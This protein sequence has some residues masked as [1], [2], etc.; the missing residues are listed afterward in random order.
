MSIFNPFIQCKLNLKNWRKVRV[1][2]DVIRN[3]AYSIN[4]P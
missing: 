1:K 3:S 4:V 2:D